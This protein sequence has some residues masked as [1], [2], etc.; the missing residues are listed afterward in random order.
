MVKEAL[1]LEPSESMSVPMDKSGDVSSLGSPITGIRKNEH[2]AKAKQVLKK[3]GLSC[4]SLSTICRWITSLGF[5]YEAHQKSYY[6]NGHEKQG[7]VD[8]QWSFVQRY[9]S[10]EQWMF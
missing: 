1:E 7:T 8:Y 10:H 5:K 9:L 2:D 6:V 4:I 3:F